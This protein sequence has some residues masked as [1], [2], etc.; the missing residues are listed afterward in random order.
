MNIE[1]YEELNKLQNN[2]HM[3]VAENEKRIKRFDVLK[4]YEKEIDLALEKLY[5]SEKLEKVEICI[6]EKNVQNGVYC[7]VRI[8]EDISLLLVRLLRLLKE[9]NELQIEKI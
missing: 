7:T 6:R 2:L 9:K 4:R 8:D 1:E 5:C 3:Q